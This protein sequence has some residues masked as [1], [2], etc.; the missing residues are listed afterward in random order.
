MNTFKSCFI[1]SEHLFLGIPLGGCFCITDIRTKTNILNKFF[2]EQCTPIKNESV[3]PT[4]EMFLTKSRLGTLDFNENE[5]L[6]IIR[7]LKIHKA[8]VHD[9]IFIR[10]IQ[11]CDRTLLKP[12]I[13]FF[14]NL[15]KYSDYPDIWK[16]SNIIPVNKKL[17]NN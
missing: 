4:N 6:K 15:G 2:E 11:I 3:L 17:I 16:R 8:H 14:Q 12:L 9:D 5:I 10:M 13:I 7:A 1:F